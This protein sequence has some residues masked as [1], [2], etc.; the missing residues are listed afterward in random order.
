ML[1]WAQA[2]IL[3]A[4]GLVQTAAGL[5]VQ[6]DLVHA[7]TVQEPHFSFH[8][9]GE[10]SGTAPI[11]L[12]TS[13]SVGLRHTRGRPPRGPRP[14][15]VLRHNSTVARQETRFARISST[16]EPSCWSCSRRGRPRLASRA[17][18]GPWSRRRD[19]RTTTKAGLRRPSRA[20][21]LHAWS[22]SAGVDA[23]VTALVLAASRP[24]VSTP[25]IG[26]TDPS[27]TL[28]VRH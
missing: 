25:S 1:A 5:L 19:A 2:A 18:Q 26:R 23:L 15:F 27:A 4:Y 28:N 8:E 10:F 3:I 16:T 17:Q 11:R 13:A 7:S 22:G 20:G 21:L 9:R 12:D 24:S 6:T 14:A